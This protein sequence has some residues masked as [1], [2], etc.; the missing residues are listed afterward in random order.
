MY[1][2]QI[3][4]TALAAATACLPLVLAAP[5]SQATTYDLVTVKQFGNFTWLENMVSIWLT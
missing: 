1:G 3:A 5:A 2:F 4:A